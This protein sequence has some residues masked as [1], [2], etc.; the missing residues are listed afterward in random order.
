MEL[1]RGHFTFILKA[2]EDWLRHK[3]DREVNLRPAQV[4]RD[5]KQKKIMAMDIVVGGVN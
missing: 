5:H 4:I 1:Y 3:A 2:Y